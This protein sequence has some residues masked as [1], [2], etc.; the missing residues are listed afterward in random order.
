MSPLGPVSQNPFLTIMPV[1]KAIRSLVMLVC[2]W[3]ECFN[4]E[5][6]S[7]KKKKKKLQQAEKANRHQYG[8]QRFYINIVC[9]VHCKQGATQE[10]FNCYFFVITIVNHTTFDLLH[11]HNVTLCNLEKPSFTNPSVW[12]LKPHAVSGCQQKSSA[13]QQ[14]AT[15]ARALQPTLRQT[16]QISEAREVSQASSTEVLSHRLKWA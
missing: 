7:A 1:D 4:H 3:W 10:L 13:S 15:I 9:H 8:R 2:F 14:R 11:L 5:S 16:Q 12:A 6:R